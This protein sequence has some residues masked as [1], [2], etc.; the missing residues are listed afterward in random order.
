MFT[1][2]FNKYIIKIRKSG[3]Y[4][5]KFCRICGK[6]LLDD[7]QF[8]DG[9]G[10]PIEE[11]NNIQAPIQEIKQ[12]DLV[13]N[14]PVE[15][16]NVEYSF[17][18]TAG[19][20]KKKSAKKLIIIACI[21]IA[22][23]II[24]IPFGKVIYRAIRDERTR[25]QIRVDKDAEYIEINQEK[26]GRLLANELERN[27]IP[28]ATVNR[29][30]GTEWTDK[31][32]FDVNLENGEKVYITSNNENTIERI[33]CRGDPKVEVSSLGNVVGVITMLL[34]PTTTDKDLKKMNDTFF[35]YDNLNSM[36]GED[37]K[38]GNLVYEWYW[39]SINNSFFQITIM[40][41]GQYKIINH[42]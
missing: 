23:I 26:F 34:V 7:S 10:T 35:K 30:K 28:V 12:E 3:V 41:E 18:Q 21:S 16:Q 36:F 37:Y 15:I 17:H 33:I 22:V 39:D 29:Y 13:N 11:V 8:C 40:P 20:P 24:G 31:Y 27:D 14:T 6:E 25:S 32:R 9:C 5:S 1:E 42:K 38:Y 2:I 4:M 19:E